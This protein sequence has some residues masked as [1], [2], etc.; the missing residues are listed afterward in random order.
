VRLFR[1]ILLA[2]LAVPLAAA[3]LD[4]S[5]LAALLD[6]A[7]LAT[8]G[9]RGANPRVQKAAHWLAVAKAQ[10]GDP[11]ALLDQ[12]LAGKM[13]PEAARLTTQ[14]LLRNLDIA[15]KLGCLDAEGLAEMRQGKAATVKRGPYAGDQLSVDHI[16]PRSV[17]PELDNVI[18]NLELM[19]QR[20][21]A[22]KGNRVGERQLS[23]ARALHEAGLLTAEG[24]RVVEAAGAVSGG[25]PMPH[26]GLYRCCHVV[27]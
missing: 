21:N 16:I 5:R 4:V 22:G 18:A 15:G 25:F 1:I 9:E 20:M 14:A 13:K 23:H 24:L 10:G 6:P 8:L 2:L 27:L 3:D 17:A 7:K 26:Q 12:A 19:P 11:A